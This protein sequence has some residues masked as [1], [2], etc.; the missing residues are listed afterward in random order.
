ME[1]YIVIVLGGAL[2]LVLLYLMS[3]ARQ[4]QAPNLT[5]TVEAPQ[6]TPVEST[7]MFEGL[8]A[9]EAQHL[10]AVKTGEGGPMEVVEEANEVPPLE[11]AEDVGE[12]SEAG[13]EAKADEP[14]EVN[15]DLSELSG[16]GS[17]YQQLLRVSGITSIQS[18]S[19]REPS[20]LMGRL[21][22]VNDRDVIVRRPPPLKTVQGWVEEARLYVRY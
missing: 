10:E 12:A 2:A 17:K 1:S 21:L 5:P 6:S 20:E 14:V 11:V 16:I 8:E 18:L 15:S 9:E 19:Q 13:V 4:R 7:P 3:R 22:E